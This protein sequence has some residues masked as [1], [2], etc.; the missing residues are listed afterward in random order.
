MSK[1]IKAGLLKL[2]M[3]T[4]RFGRLSNRRGKIT[5]V[6]NFG[7]YS[8]RHGHKSCLIKSTQVNIERRV[9]VVIQK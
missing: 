8:Y 5:P 1:E 6:V 4:L 2:K 3:Y 7:T 9:P